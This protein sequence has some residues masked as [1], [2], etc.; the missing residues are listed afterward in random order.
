MLDSLVQPPAFTS[1]SK[2]GCD[3][4]F[5][6]VLFLL[7]CGV[8]AKPDWTEAQTSGAVWLNSKCSSVRVSAA[9]AA[10]SCLCGRVCF[11]ESDRTA[12]VFS[13]FLFTLPLRKLRL[14]MF[15]NRECGCRALANPPPE[16]PLVLWVFFSSFIR[17]LQPEAGQSVVADADECCHHLNSAKTCCVSFVLPCSLF[18]SLPN[19][20]V[21]ILQ[22]SYVFSKNNRSSR[23][24]IKDVIGL[25]FVSSTFCI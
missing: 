23:F 18:F 5:A 10:P 21:V 15:C 25:I 2:P 14:W 17:S 22:F 6:V 13:F 1:P 11:P 4:L 7:C 12:T 19:S 3:W 24:L 16:Q 20:R 9:A 8:P